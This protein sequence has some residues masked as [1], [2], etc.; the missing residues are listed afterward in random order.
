MCATC[1]FLL[2]GQGLLAYTRPMSA[3]DSILAAYAITTVLVAG[4]CIATWVR[5]RRVAKALAAQERSKR[6]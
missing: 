2:A 1:H 5:A 4:L 3:D 6:A